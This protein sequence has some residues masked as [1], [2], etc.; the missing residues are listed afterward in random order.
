MRDWWRDAIIYQ[1]YPRSFQDSDGDGIGDLPGIT[2][3]LPHIASLGA[4]VVWLSPFFTSP[5]RDMGYDVSDYCNVNPLFGT[6]EDFDALLAKAHD[7]GLKVIIDQVISHSSIDHPWFKE[8]RQSRETDKADWYVWADPKADGGPPTNWLSVFG[9]SAWAWDTRR[10]QYYLHN[11][12]I[13]QPDLNFHNP[14]VVDTLLGTMRFWLERGVDGFRLDTVNFYVHDARLRDNPASEW[15]VFPNNPYEAQNHLF[16]KTRPENI[17][18]LQRIRTLTDEFGA[19]MT[20]GEVGE[21]GRMIE[22]MAEYT[23]GGDKL[24]MAYSFEFLGPD[25]APRHF[26]SGIERFLRSAPDG[27]PCWAF[28]NHDVAR[29]VSRWTPPGGD[30]DAVAKQAIALLCS[31]P[32][33]LCLYQGEELGQTETDILYEE[34]RDLGY[35]DFWPAI[36]GRDGCRTP[37]V[38]KAQDPQGGFTTGTPWLPVKPPQ[39]TR[40]VD[41]QEK[42]KASVLNAYRATIAYRRGRTALRTGTTR[43][44]DLPAPLLAIERTAED[45][46]R[47]TAIFNLSDQ[48][49]ELTAQGSFTLAGPQAAEGK[50]PVLMFPA[51]GFVFLESAQ[52]LMLAQLD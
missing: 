5:D 7:L 27:W 13:E 17:A 1:V 2:A 42:D 8:S 38:W 16:S 50:G 18:I 34:V 6:L 44:I 29:H 10:K 48:P 33:T 19:T 11:F 32:G 20:V 14:D 23:S 47:V 51:H 31:F 9:G 12:L 46:A 30:S 15:D 41:R 37:M 52:P 40:A 36:K 28:S 49:Q 39:A 43:F 3:R 22:I 4:D 45:G 35:I 25:T 24:H 26:R 21:A